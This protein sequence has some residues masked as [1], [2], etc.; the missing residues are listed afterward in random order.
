MVLQFRVM[1]FSVGEG[2]KARRV[3]LAGIIEQQQ[4][5]RAF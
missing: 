1:K 5:Y 2:T 3:T 4:S